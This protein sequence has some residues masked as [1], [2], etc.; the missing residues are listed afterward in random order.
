MLRAARRVTA[1]AVLLPAIVALALG[2][3]ALPTAADTAGVP[4]ATERL[5]IAWQ[6][7][8]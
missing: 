2:A 3:Q 7:S 4:A 8:R 1:V 5:I 6:E